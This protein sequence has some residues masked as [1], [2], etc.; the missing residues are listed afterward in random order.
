MPPSHEEER[1]A[2]LQ[3]TTV[4]YLLDRLPLLNRV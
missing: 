2:I 3:V 1:T 4:A